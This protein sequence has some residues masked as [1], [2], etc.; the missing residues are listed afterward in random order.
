MQEGPALKELC[1]P[2]RVGGLQPSVCVCVGGAGEEDGP[3]NRLVGNTSF[4]LT[5]VVNWGKTAGGSGL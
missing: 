4:L 1:R 3:G 2:W 5:C